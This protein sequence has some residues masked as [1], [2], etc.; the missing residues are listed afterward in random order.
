MSGQYIKMN[1]GE[2]KCD[3]VDWIHLAHAGSCE[4]GNDPSGSIKAGNF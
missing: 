1:P 2:T 3:D 4:S